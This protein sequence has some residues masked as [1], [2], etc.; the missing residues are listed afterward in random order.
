MRILLLVHD[1]LPAHPS[2]TEVYTGA[3]A[4]RLAER[5][6]EVRLFATEK[7][8]SR[9]HLALERRTWEGLTVHELVN[10]LFY[11]DFRETWDYPPAE[12]AFERVLDEFRP[13]VVHVMH[14]LYLSVGCVE[15]ARRRKVPVFFTLHDFWL[16]CARF[17]Q[18]IHADGAV[19][20]TIDFD[21]C[22]T[23]LARLKFAQ[24]PFERGAA[25]V[26]A[27]VKRASGVD[28]APLA[29][30]AV[31]RLRVTPREPAQPAPEAARRFAELARA[32]ES[33]LRLRLVPCV[34]RFFAPSAFLRERFREWGLPPE[35]LE[36][37]AYGLELEPFQDLERTRSERLRIAFLGT[38]APHKAPHLVLEAFARLAPELRAR[39]TLTLHGPKQHFPEYVAGLERRAAEVGARLAGTLARADVP[40]TLAETDV[41][42]VP[43]VWYENSPLTIHEA[44]AARTPVLV[45]DLG[46]MSELVE[47][48][49]QGWRFRAGD[50]A[51]LAKEL[52]RLVRWPER[53]LTLDLGPP[54]KDMRTSAAELEERYARALAGEVRR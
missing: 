35:R 6:H 49:K 9:P 24:S 12:A 26:I 31:E 19:C 14:L 32:R 17:G 3:L 4:L 20:H 33:E 41:L 13:D 54:P 38:L 44:R 36:T 25:R 52:E 50:A 51:D 42:V 10:N 1:F 45:S 18:R 29:R 53:L 22:G 28:L 48:G 46:G 8:I 21:R 30:A 15:A 5:G 23:C 34:E 7:D 27:G 40:R 16:Q 43:S 37:L 11:A 47:P 39:A 2:G